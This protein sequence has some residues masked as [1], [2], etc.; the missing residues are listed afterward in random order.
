MRKFEKQVVDD[1]GQRQWEDIDPIDIKAGDSFRV[2]EDDGSVVKRGNRSEFLAVKDGQ[3]VSAT[4][5]V[6]VFTMDTDSMFSE[7]VA[8]KDF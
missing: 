7:P 1:N 2:H 5:A 8:G 6:V 3:S 4:M